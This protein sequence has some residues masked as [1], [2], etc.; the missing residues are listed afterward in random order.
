MNTVKKLLCVGPGG[1]NC[2]C[3]FPAPGKRKEVF[4]SAKRKSQRE[5]SKFIAESISASKER[6]DD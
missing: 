2:A 6:L 1:M 5:I 4:R 3:C